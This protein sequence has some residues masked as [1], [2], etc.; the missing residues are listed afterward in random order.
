MWCF[1]RIVL[2]VVVLVAPLALA[3]TAVHPQT[4]PP[5]PA[6]GAGGGEPGQLAFCDFWPIALGNNWHYVGGTR[7]RFTDQ[8][9]VNG[10]DVWEVTTDGFMGITGPL[11][12]YWVFVDGWLYGTSDPADLEL[13]PDLGPGMQAQFPEWFT[14]GEPFVLPSLGMTVTPLA[15]A[16]SDFLPAIGLTVDDF[17][18]GD[19]PDTLALLFETGAPVIILGR[20]LGPLFVF[21][22]DV[23]ESATVLAGC[24]DTGESGFAFTELPQGGWMEE[25]DQL[26]LTVGVAETV[27][28]VSYQWV[29]DGAVVPAQTFAT[30]MIDTLTLDDEGWYS[31]RVTDGSKALFVATDPVEVAVFPAGSLPTAGIAGLCILGIACAAAARMVDR[32]GAV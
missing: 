27:G 2:L 22:S 18:L 15:G 32:R 12:G 25:G 31:V 16:L 7:L 24:E 5:A 23:L 21:A 29:K 13:L 9:L 28:P 4:P 8:L 10:F 30:Y 1:S 11:V 26:S 3:Q 19:H 14:P 6:P 17:P 20:D